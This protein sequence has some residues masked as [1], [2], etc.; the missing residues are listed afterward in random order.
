METTKTQLLSVV[1]ACALLAGCASSPPV[2]FVAA[3]LIDAQAANEKASINVSAS[4]DMLR[5][6]ITLTICPH[7]LDSSESQ[8]DCRKQGLFDKLH[9]LTRSI[10]Y[11]P[12]GQILWQSMA[13]SLS[14]HGIQPR[15]RRISP[16]IQVGDHS[17]RYQRFNNSRTTMEP[18]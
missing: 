14:K 18:M 12:E 10:L 1:L 13:T 8:Q 4:A 11:N 5:M 16:A 15:T 17:T 2:T 7:A 9:L 3:S 6:F